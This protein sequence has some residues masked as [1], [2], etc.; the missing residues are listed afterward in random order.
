M[1]KRLAVVFA[2]VALVYFTGCTKKPEQPSVEETAQAT[3]EPETAHE[4]TAPAAGEPAPAPAPEPEELVMPDTPLEDLTKNAATG[5]TLHLEALA[6]YLLD[7][8]NPDFDIPKGCETLKP[9]LSCSTH[10]LTYWQGWCSWVEGQRE[11][12]NDLINE[13]LAKISKAA[14]NQYIPAMEFLI[15]YDKDMPYEFVQT[16]VDLYKKQLDENAT[17]ETQYHYA[18]LLINTRTEVPQEAIDTIQ[19]A[20]DADYAP[21]MYFYG[22]KLKE[23]ASKEDKTKGTELIAK[24]AELGDK[25]A[26][27]IVIGDLAKTLRAAANPEDKL[28]AL[29]KVI[30]ASDKTP[31]CIQAC[32]A[33]LDF[34]TDPNESINK[35]TS[36]HL[37]ICIRAMQPERWRCDMIRKSFE[38]MPPNDFSKDLQTTITNALID[39]YQNVIRNGD[40]SPWD[41]QKTIPRNAKIIEDLKKSIQ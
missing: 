8:S 11:G 30:Q 34:S 40:E 15:D 29:N 37:P 7:K 1:T 2:A 35:L 36:E 9:I 23:S 14:D 21:A 28:I 22:T 16:L 33:F 19:K 3:N 38:K 25:E 41:G 32:R 5:E 20:I 27:N 6:K 31:G 17:P 26:A 4:E 24:A 39:C 18:K 10:E 13:G 12:N